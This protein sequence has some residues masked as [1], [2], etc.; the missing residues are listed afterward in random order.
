MSKY[1]TGELA[2]LCCVTVRTVQ[3]YDSRGILTPSELTEGG[4]RLYNDNDLKK[5]KVICFL[6]DMGLSINTISKIMKDDDPQSVVSLLIE[7]HEKDLTSELIDVQRKLESVKI[8]KKELREAEDFSVNTIS[9]IA[10]IMKNKDKMKKFRRNFIIFALAIE[11]VEIAAILLWVFTGVWLPF[12]V[13]TVLEI[14]IVLA[15]LVPYYYKKV[16]Y[17]CP[18]CH[19]TFKPKYSQMLFSNHT[20]KTRKLLC[21][22]CNEKKWCVE[23]YDESSDNKK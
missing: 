7:E 8:L 17:I 12:A 3:Y 14:I 16:S 18:C 13:Y 22:H 10:L 9:D 19:E 5:L 6:R 11:A 23:V 15:F 2:K 1:T 21:P 20:Y 4:R